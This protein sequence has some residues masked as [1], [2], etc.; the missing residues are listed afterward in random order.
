MTTTVTTEAEV[1]YSDPFIVSF[2]KLDPRA[3]VPERKT[4]GSAG[5]DLVPIEGGIVHPGGL[6]RFRTGLAVALPSFY[7]ARIVPRS[8]RFIEGWYI[9]GTLDSDYR[10]DITL[11]LRNVSNGPLEVKAGERYAQLLVFP[12]YAGMTVE[13]DVLSET[14]RGDKGFG[15][16]GK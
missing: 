1:R 10:G 14:A 11:Q 4:A 12:Y 7:V 5:L 8:S 9:D 13:V 2:K 6:G 15:S 3:I 16:T